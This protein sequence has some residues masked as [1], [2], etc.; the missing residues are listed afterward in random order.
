MPAAQVGGGL[1]AEEV[2]RIDPDT[3]RHARRPVAADGEPVIVGIDIR[4]G[5]TRGIRAGGYC[6][7]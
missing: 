5:T 7:P 2:E 4:I 6:W 3:G 1:G